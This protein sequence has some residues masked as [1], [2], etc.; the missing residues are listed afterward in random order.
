MLDKIYLCLLILFS[1][2]YF[3]KLIVNKN[4]KYSI[5]DYLSMFAIWIF[6][7]YNPL[8][9][10][11]FPII[12]L[13]FMY[14]FFYSKVKISKELKITYISLF[15]IVI[16]SVFI[17]FFK[18]NIYYGDHKDTIYSL[19]QFAMLI[20]LVITF[21]KNEYDLNNIIKLYM[22]IFIINIII[23]II[24]ITTGMHMSVS[25]IYEYSWWEYNWPTSY[26]Y[27]INDF[28]VYLVLSMPIVY[29][30]LYNKFKNKPIFLFI[31]LTTI[32]SYI[33]FI[34]IFI[35][36]KM[37]IITILI[38]IAMLTYYYIN[39]V[40]KLKKESKV[41]INLF[42]LICIFIAVLI[43]EHKHKL[44]NGLINE[45]TIKER[46]LLGVK[47]IEISLENI[48]GIGFKSFDNYSIVEESIIPGLF[49]EI[50]RNMPPHNFFLELIVSC[51][52]ISIPFIISFYIII[53]KLYCYKKNIPE[54]I[55]FFSSVSFFVVSL[56]SASIVVSP[57]FFTWYLMIISYIRYKNLLI[58]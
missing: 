22:Y 1:I 18:K 57:A 35:D 55:L 29:F 16:Y 6:L 38:T 41:L 12:C 36:A 46:I 26:F 15:L 4:S 52:I 58:R 24:E 40:L 11:A 54:Q 32:Y 53:K 34:C 13:C 43:I 21:I 30:Y 25:G 31:S 7:L 39:R 56:S 5:I 2:I 27:N 44:I 50:P 51:G 20:Y 17:L 23:S 3:I 48:G 10:I 19:L 45:L 37:L 9:Q 42:F 14:R 33:L 49:G 47:A 28:G 8:K